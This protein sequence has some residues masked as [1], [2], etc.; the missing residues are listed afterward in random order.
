VCAAASGPAS[1]ASFFTGQRED[2]ERR[3]ERE[4]GGEERE[5]ERALAMRSPFYKCFN[6]CTPKGQ[7]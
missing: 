2:M 1:K 7:V 4:K 6:L 3:E 5:R